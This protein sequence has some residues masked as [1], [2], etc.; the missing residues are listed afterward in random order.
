MMV[1][2]AL[3]LLLVFFAA[4]R[5]DA[6]PVGGGRAPPRAARGR[7]RA[8]GRGAGLSALLERL[9]VELP[10]VQAGHGRRHRRGTSWPR[11]SRTPA[12]SGRSARDP[13]TLLARELA[14]SR[15]RDRARR[16]RSTCCCRSRAPAHW[17]VA[18]R[19]RRGRHVLGPAACGARPGSGCTSAGRSTRSATAR[20]A[21]ADGVIVQGVEA[22]GHVRGATAGA[23]A[24]G[25]RRAR[26]VGAGLP[27]AAG[28]RRSPRPSDVRDGAGGGRRRRRAGHALRDERRVR[29][30]GRPTSSG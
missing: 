30:R 6:D 9:G 2:Q 1:E 24:A 8:R 14:A 29:R 12:A 15:E 13:P 18:R 3:V 10:V 25:A 5:E 7:R 27:G 20:A 28:R 19:G 23:R 16:S 4:V 11:R 17:R 21:G 22:G 26:R